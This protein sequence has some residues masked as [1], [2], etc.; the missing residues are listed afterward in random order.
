MI[1]RQLTAAATAAVNLHGLQSLRSVVRSLVGAISAAI[2]T[3]I[4][5]VPVAMPLV[6]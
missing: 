3:A 6:I 2:S 4:G 1:N 5:A